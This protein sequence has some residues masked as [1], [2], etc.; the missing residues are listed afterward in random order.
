M[1]SIEIIDSTHFN[2][3]DR[4]EYS[5]TDLAAQIETKKHLIAQTILNRA[6]ETQAQVQSI[7]NDIDAL[8]ADID[9]AVAAGATAPNP[10]TVDVSTIVSSVNTLLTEAAALA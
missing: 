7:Q 3:V 10:S 9:S 2:K 4:V 6:T 1:S 8:Q 5:V